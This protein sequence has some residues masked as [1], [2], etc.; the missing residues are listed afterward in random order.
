MCLDLEMS[1]GD[2]NLLHVSLQLGDEENDTNCLLFMFMLIS[3]FQCVFNFKP[4]PTP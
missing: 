4:V 1:A 3:N 2:L